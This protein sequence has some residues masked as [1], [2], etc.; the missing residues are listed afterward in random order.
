MPGAEGD[1]GGGL[2][3]GG[4]GDGGGGGEAQLPEPQ[5]PG[6]VLVWPGQGGC[7]LEH[8]AHVCDA[9]RVEAQ[10]LVER[11]RDVEHGVHGCDVGRVE[12]QGL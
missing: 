12:A 11:R 6:Q 8:L 7:T 1:G 2:G 5:S 10:R 9:G 4:G 3:D